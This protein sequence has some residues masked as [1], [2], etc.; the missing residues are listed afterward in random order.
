MVN[1]GWTQINTDAQKDQ[2]QLTANEREIREWER[3]RRSLHPMMGRKKMATKEHREHERREGNKPRKTR[4][5]RTKQIPRFS[6]GE[7]GRSPR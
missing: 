1:H 6:A 2:R 3:S 5:M 7:I 4:N